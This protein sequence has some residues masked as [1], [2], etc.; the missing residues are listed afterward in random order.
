MDKY[1]NDPTIQ[2]I[3]LELT[4]DLQVV[5]TVDYGLWTTDYG[6]RTTDYGLRTTDYGKWPHYNNFTSINV[7]YGFDFLTHFSRPCFLFDFILLDRIV[8]LVYQVE[9]EDLVGA[10]DFVGGFFACRPPHFDISQKPDQG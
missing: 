4:S 6:L 8:S 7:D 1:F 3:E 5:M 9:P 10:F 2:D